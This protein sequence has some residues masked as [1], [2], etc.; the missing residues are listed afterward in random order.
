MAEISETT[1]Q[2]VAREKGRL[3][4]EIAQIERD[5]AEW[6]RLTKSAEARR[7]SLETEK[8]ALNADIPAPT[9]VEDNRVPSTEV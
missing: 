9:I 5:I 4:Q 8:A 2:I 3:E 6:S 7:A 1:K